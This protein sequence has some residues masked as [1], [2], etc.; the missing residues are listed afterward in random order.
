MDVLAKELGLVVSARRT[1]KQY[2][3][4]LLEP[5][6]YASSGVGVYASHRG[7]EINLSVFRAYGEDGIANTLLAALGDA[8]GVSMRQ[9]KDWPA[10]PC[11]KVLATWT[12]IRSDVLE[13]YF[14]ARAGHAEK[15]PV[16]PH[17]GSSAGTADSPALADGG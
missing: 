9:A 2:L 7:M 8:T 4:R 10:V 5:V 1:G 15:T 11:A 16:D 6:S 3:P 12:R 13:P 14:R 17:P